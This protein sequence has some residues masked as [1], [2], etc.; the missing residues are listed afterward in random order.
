VLISTTLVSI[1]K[2]YDIVLT[3]VNLYMQ[4]P[5]GDE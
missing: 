3:I 5:A 4:V 1:E 2:I